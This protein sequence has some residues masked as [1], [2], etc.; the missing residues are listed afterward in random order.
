[1]RKF[2]KAT[3]AVAIV[4]TCG[5]VFSCTDQE[6]RT[7]G[8]VISKTAITQ[9]KDLGFDVSDIRLIPDHNPITGASGKNNY[10]LEGDIVITPENL[11]AMI[12]SDIFHVG[13]VEEQYRTNN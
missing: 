2:N 9:F 1:M 11:K 3:I 5:F 4:T 13:A 8:Q 6:V 12:S 7:D 10:L